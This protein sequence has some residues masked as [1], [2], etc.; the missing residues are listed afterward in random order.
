MLTVQLTRTTKDGSSYVV[1]YEV[2]VRE[3][4]TVLQVLNRIYE[5]YE[6]TLAYRYACRIGVCGT[7]SAMV[8]GRPELVCLK[9]VD[10][11]S[12]NKVLEIA[13]LPR[14][15]TIADLAKEM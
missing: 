13:P 10:L 5:K 9:K 11:E 14:R 12:E 6:P 2:E 3:N 15:N 1:D 8:N 4:D 7:C